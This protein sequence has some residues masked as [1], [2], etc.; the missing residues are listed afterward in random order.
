MN[1]GTVVTRA[2]ARLAR[3][4]GFIRQEHYERPNGHSY[5]YTAEAEVFE[6]WLLDKPTY[7]D[8]PSHVPL[9]TILDGLLKLAA[10]DWCGNIDID[11]NYP[12]PDW[13]TLSKDDNPW[14]AYMAD[15]I[16]LSSEHN[17]K[18]CPKRCRWRVGIGGSKC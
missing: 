3:T 1:S 11:F 9:C 16:T 12:A 13:P 8:L 7:G 2:N 10:D 18:R 15:G 17:R 4:Q 6:R 14:H 5:S